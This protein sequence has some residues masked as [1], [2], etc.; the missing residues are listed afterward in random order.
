MIENKSISLLTLGFHE[1]KCPC[2]IGAHPH[3]RGIE[4]E[5]LITLEVDIEVTK[6]LHS[7]LLEDTVDYTALMR[8]CSDVAKRRHYHLLETLAWEILVELGETF[9]LIRAQ[10]KLEK[11]LTLSPARASFIKMERF[12]S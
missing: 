3:E 5:L 12:Y 11:T 9:P 2:E 1:L 4:Q 7:D 6:C 10:I 8:C